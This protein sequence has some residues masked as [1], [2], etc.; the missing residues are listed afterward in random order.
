[1][2]FR[3]F[4]AATLSFAAAPAASA[5]PPSRYWELGWGLYGGE[6]LDA[7]RFDWHM[8][9]FGNVGANE[10]TVAALNEMLV[11]NPRH[12]FLIRVWPIMGLGDCPENRHQATL[13]HY[14]YKPGVR[15]KVLAETKRQ[16][17]LVCQGVTRPQNVYGS[18]FLEEL[19]GH[20]TSSPFGR[21]W[22]P[23]DDL[24]WDIKRFR[25]E[26]ETELGEPLDWASEKHRLWW[27][28]KYCQVLGEIHRAMKEA[29][30]GKPVF[31]YQAT[32]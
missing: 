9:S 24:P 1:M 23:D 14:L 30:R 4:L 19:P 25:K 21:K 10:K 8:I 2:L 11:L 15:E 7:A 26:I 17:E 18:C 31:Y 6:G 29:S 5:A 12:K 32:A 16:I 3:S 22:K 28:R 13:F 20:F 27:G